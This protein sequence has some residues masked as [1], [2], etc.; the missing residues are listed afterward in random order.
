MF[1]R[2]GEAFP[3]PPCVAERRAATFGD[4]AAIAIASC[5]FDEIAIG[6]AEVHRQYLTRR[7][8]PQSWAFDYVNALPAQMRD[9]FIHRCVSEQTKLPLPGNVRLASP[10]AAPAP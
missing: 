9:Y 5:Y 6:V 4:F 8:D 7:S 2:D 10:G 1:A 3:P